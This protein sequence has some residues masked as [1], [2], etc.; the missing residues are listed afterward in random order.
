MTNE[1]ALNFDPTERTAVMGES[2]IAFARSVKLDE[3][4]RPLIRQLVRS[5]TSIGA[6]YVEADEADTK[7]EFKYR[8]GLARRE[9]R[10]T[11]HWLRMIVHASPAMRETAVNVYREADE[12]VRIFSKIKA[13]TNA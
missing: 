4:T 6:N 10:E 1:K 3:V 5:G 11:M 8:I 9:S 12:L 7:K 13:S 2:V